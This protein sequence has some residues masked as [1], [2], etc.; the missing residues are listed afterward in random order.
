MNISFDRTDAIPTPLPRRHG[1]IL[2]D[3]YPPADTLPFL[4]LPC[5]YTRLCS[6]AQSGC[7]WDS[8]AGAD[9]DTFLIR[10]RDGQREGFPWTHRQITGETPNY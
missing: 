7:S 4:L 8:L 5:Y 3:H 6:V 2:I 10:E 9:R 1:L